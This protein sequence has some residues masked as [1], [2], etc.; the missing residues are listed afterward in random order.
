MVASAIDYFLCCRDFRFGR[1]IESLRIGG[2]LLDLAH[3]ALKAGGPAFHLSNRLLHSANL[4]LGCGHVVGY[5]CGGAW[6]RRNRRHRDRLLTTQR[7]PCRGCFLFAGTLQQIHGDG[8]QLH[9]SIRRALLVGDVQA[10]NNEFPD[11]SPVSG[12]VR[13]HLES[14]HR[15]F[16][17][18]YL[19]LRITKF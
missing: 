14:V 4:F 13:Q 19:G 9:P 7:P 17:R 12:N 18:I 8:C 5:T 2:Q 16:Q 3:P 15:R 1:R 11:N 10:R 6:S